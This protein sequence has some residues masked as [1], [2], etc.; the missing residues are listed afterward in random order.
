MTS[1]V[2]HSDGRYSMPPPSKVEKVPSINASNHACWSSGL[3]NRT[4]RPPSQKSSV[5]SLFHG[6]DGRSRGIVRQLKVICW[7]LRSTVI[8]YFEP[9]GKLS[10]SERTP[11]CSETLTPLMA[12]ILSP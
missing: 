6:K 10:S 8:E 12:I 2:N 7:P 11:G 4:S 5:T 3:S 9:G 1:H